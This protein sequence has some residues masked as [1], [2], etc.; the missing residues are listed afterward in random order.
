MILPF[1][2]P[3]RPGELLYSAFARYGVCRGLTSPKAV[4]GELFGRS[5][6]I[7]TPDLPNN[8][9]AFFERL[10]ARSR[11]REEEVLNRHTLYAYY[12]A[13]QP[14]ERRT[15]ANAAMLGRHGNLHV[16]LGLAA[17]RTGRPTHLQF[18]PMCVAEMERVH[19]CPHWRTEHQ[20][21]GVLVCTEH[22]CR[23]RR[24]QVQL[25]ATN[26]HAFIPAS[27]AVCALDCDAITASLSGRS[28]DRALDLARA[29]ASLLDASPPAPTAASL[30]DG[31]RSRLAVAGLIRGRHK[32]DQ[33]GLEGG[34]RDFFGGLLDR[35]Q[36]VQLGASETW[37]NSIVRTS[38][39]AHPPLQHLLL[40]TFLDAQ[41]GCAPRAHAERQKALAVCRDRAALAPKESRDWNRTDIQY[42]ARIRARAH[43]LRTMT[44]PVRVTAAAIERG[45]NG[46]DWL[47]KRRAKLP[48]S[49]KAMRE[50]TEDIE[51][52]RSRRLRWHAARCVEGGIYDPWTI[53]KRAGLP[54]SHI[55]SVRAE[56]ASV[57]AVRTRSIAA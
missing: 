48:L 52:F 42:A 18:C 46:R 23:L 30:R 17:F 39:G 21:P 26:R 10:P 27:R 51:T 37:L 16:I 54:H 35:L 6:T 25:A 24:S 14:L 50:V 38:G 3:P 15:A 9:S 2:S 31:Y 32:V 36:G 47:C 5:D 13:Y 11:E 19:G 55:T 28:L 22:G 29:S 49:A 56:L 40:E 44:P 41:P 8:L 53:L 33:A 1:F 57:L 12:T 4:M 7:A 34:L 20:L 43:E 45:A